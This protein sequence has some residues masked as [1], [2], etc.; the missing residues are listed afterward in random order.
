MN[1]VI[2]SYNF[3]KKIVIHPETLNSLC[4]RTETLKS[5]RRIAN[6]YF[7]YI[8]MNTLTQHF[9]PLPMHYVDN[10]APGLVNKDPCY[11][12]LQKI[13]FY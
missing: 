13:Y 12:E 3:H 6:K 7:N 1:L 10:I 11:D 2:N 8:T 9:Y 4:H 5:H